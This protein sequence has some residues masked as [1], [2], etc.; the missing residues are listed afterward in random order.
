MASRRWSPDQSGLR[1]IRRSRPSSPA[2]GWPYAEFETNKKD[3]EGNFLAALDRAPAFSG[4]LR[5]GKR[6]DRF[7]VMAVPNFFRKPYGPGWALVKSQ[8]G[9]SRSRVIPRS[10]HRP[11]SCPTESR[12]RRR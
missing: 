2:I 8:L 4:R 10:K 7:Y 5:A 1:P 9:T 3:V 11:F 12:L 6:E